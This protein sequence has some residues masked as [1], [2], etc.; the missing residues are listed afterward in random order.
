MEEVIRPNT[1]TSFVSLWRVSRPAAFAEFVSDR[2]LDRVRH[3]VK[4]SVRK[5]QIQDL[6]NG[7]DVVNLDVLEQLLLDILSY[8]L[9][10]F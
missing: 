1:T 9:F 2:F 7:P 5:S 6:F 3:N 4:D 8:V 10:G